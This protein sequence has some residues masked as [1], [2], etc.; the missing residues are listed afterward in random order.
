MAKRFGY[1]IAVL[2]SQRVRC[3]RDL[4]MLRFPG[5]A[6]VLRTILVPTMALL[7]ATARC[8]VP[9]PMAP[10]REAKVSE[11]VSLDSEYV[12]PMAEFE[13]G[14][15]LVFETEYRKAIEP[16]SNAFE[17]WEHLP[18]RD[19][20]YYYRGVAY[21]C[22]EKYSEAIA[23]LTKAIEINPDY[24]YYHSRG[25]ARRNNKDYHTALEDFNEAIR[26]NPEDRIT[27][28]ATAGLLACTPIDADRNSVRAVQLAIAACDAIYAN[29]ENFH[30]LACAYASNGEFDRAV[31]WE[32]KAR[33]KFLAEKAD[34]NRPAIIQSSAKL[35]DFE[36]RLE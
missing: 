27:L 1:D 15:G 22:L 12:D 24:Y 3:M 33:D 7:P 28:N 9:D 17:N 26:Q 25:V 4:E 18:K 21:E 14:R 29:S 13:L 11:Q 34:K 6:F 10:S 32:L 35:E 36:K 5:R 2:G 8:D 31:E 16:L 30:T 19:E 20:P 23:D